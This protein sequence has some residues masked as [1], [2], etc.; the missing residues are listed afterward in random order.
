M[1]LSRAARDLSN[2]IDR[3]K[4]IVVQIDWLMKYDAYLVHVVVDYPARK[5]RRLDGNHVRS[6]T[7]RSKVDV[8]P[9]LWRQTVA[10]KKRQTTLT[11][12]SCVDYEPIGNN[13]VL[14][15]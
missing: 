12:S 4:E 7:K 5:R 13:T 2:L 6:L 15:K 9:D 14:I 3:E 8:A 1:I 11:Q 10:M